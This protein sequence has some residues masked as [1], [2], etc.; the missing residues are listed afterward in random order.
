MPFSF[1]FHYIEYF[2]LYSMGKEACNATL[3]SQALDEILKHPPGYYDVVMMEH[4]NTDCGMSVAH[5]LQAPVIAMSSC[6]LM[7]WHYERFGVP[8]I[9]SYISALFQGQSQEMSLAGRLG[10]WITVHSLNLLYK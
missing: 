10:N 9:P 4:F 7:P 1:L 3:N 5:V 8:L 6:A 2:I